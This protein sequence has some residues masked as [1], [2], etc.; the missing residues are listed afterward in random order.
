MQTLLDWSYFIRKMSLSVPKMDAPSGVVNAPTGNQTERITAA[1]LE[2]VSTRWIITVHGKLH[3]SLA[4]LSWS[5]K[6][7]FDRVGGVVGENSFKFFVQFV[8]YA[9]LYCLFVVVVTAIY[10]SEDLSNTVRLQYHPTLIFYFSNFADLSPVG[11][12]RPLCG[13]CRGVG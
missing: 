7:N 5:P 3:N 4:D 10:L 1:I 9:F 6:T 12:E 2:D 8:A 11:T 13:S